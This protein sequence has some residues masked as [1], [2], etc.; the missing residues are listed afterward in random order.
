MV[1]NFLG[2]RKR[3]PAGDLVVKGSRH[4]LI[5]IGVMVKVQTV[6]LLVLT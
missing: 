3:N 6:L 1:E 2:C 4:V 5:V